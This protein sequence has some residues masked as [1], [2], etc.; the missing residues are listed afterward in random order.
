MIRHRLR[1]WITKSEPARRGSRDRK[2]RRFARLEGL[3]D[4]ML[5]AATIYSVDNTSGNVIGEGNTGSVPYVLNLANDNVNAAGS[6]IQFDP[7]VFSTPQTITLNSTLQLSNVDGPE[8]IDGPGANLVT[9]N[10]NNLIQDFLVDT[11]ATAT[12]AGLTISGGNSE[13][14]GGIGNKGTLTLND[15]MINNNY[16]VGLGAGIANVGT[17]NVNNC[18]VF[19]NSGTL[20]GGGIYTTGTLSVTGCTISANSSELYGGGIYIDESGTL[21]LSDSTVENNTTGSS[22]TGGATPG[23]GGIC[24]DGLSVT[25]TD[26]TIAANTVSPNGNGAGIDNE[27]S[28]MLTGCSVTNNQVIGGGLGGGIYSDGASLSVIGSTI[29]SN[30]DGTTSGATDNGGGI[31]ATNTVVITDSTIADNS[32]QGAGGGIYTS[33]ML[34]AVNT[35]VAYNNTTGSEGGSGLY[36]AGGTTALYNTIVA[37]NKLGTVALPGDDDD[38]D[39][40]GGTVSLSS[41]DNLIGI[42]DSGYLTNGVNGNQVNGDQVP[43]FNPGL[44]P[45]G[46]LNN[47]GPTQ[48]IALVAGSPAINAGSV[49]LDG[50][51]AT[52]Q[53]GNGRTFN[54]TIDIGAVESLPGPNFHVSGPMFVDWGTAGVEPLQISSNSINLLPPGRKNDLPWYGIDRLQVS[55]NQPAVL[56]AADVTLQSA[57]GIDY[58]PVTIT[59]MG[60]SYTIMF[61]KP[62][63][64]ADR[65]T[66]SISI[67]HTDTFMG[68]LNVLPGDFYDTGV[69]TSKD[70]SAIKNEATGKHGAAPTIFGDILGNGTVNSTDYRAAKHFLETRLP[71]LSTTGGKRPKVAL[72]RLSPFASSPFAP[73]P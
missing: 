48:T 54:G 10:G 68:Q 56:T 71:K 63:D 26:S 58:G 1:G 22:K 17:M 19:S 60:T 45:N 12:L 32:T 20:E 73:R 23:G 50:G 24:S 67:P 18:T 61:A 40:V 37:L 59:G 42:E 15:C 14:G 49:A 64:N 9:I 39:V 43:G 6:I 69:V 44:D 55:F 62:I 66:F 33:G 25:L 36:I 29:A 28:M 41:A 47:G 34:T 16:S 72:A 51:Q 35:T 3:E 31:A 13:T 70:L 21:A 4:R 65:L 52:D 53:C 46:L 2:C 11:G 5:L 8:V 30:T 7:M 57:R 27:N 38:V